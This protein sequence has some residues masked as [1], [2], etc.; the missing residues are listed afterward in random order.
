VAKAISKMQGKGG[1]KGGGGSE[2]GSWVGGEVEL[3]K[4]LRVA[5]K[6]CASEQVPYAT[7][8]L[9]KRVR[10]M[11]T[12]VKRIKLTGDFGGR[13]LGDRLTV[14]PASRRH[15]H[16]KADERRHG[17]NRAPKDGKRRE[18]GRIE[19][20]LWWLKLVEV[21]DVRGRRDLGG[22]SRLTD[23]WWVD[24]LYGRFWV[25][26]ELWCEHWKRWARRTVL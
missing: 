3:V 24:D 19:S 8:T 13:R 10:G 18:G 17:R 25:E 1:C 23:F 22:R 16:V 4:G 14:W 12:E 7:T 20:L 21:V 26:G 2:V 5:E 6:S 9:A 15:Q 11:N